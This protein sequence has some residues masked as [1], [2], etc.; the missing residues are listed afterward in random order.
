MVKRERRLV[1][2]W[3][4]QGE[5]PLQERGP[6]I[7]VPN[8][9]LIP[10][11]LSVTIPTILTIVTIASR[12]VMAANFARRSKGAVIATLI[13]VTREAAQWS[14]LAPRHPELRRWQDFVAERV[15]P[16]LVAPYAQ[17]LGHRPDREAP[18]GW[19]GHKFTKIV[20]T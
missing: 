4:A 2:G 20:P 19:R 3:L 5:G 11:V 13:T 12:S 7:L 16:W 10:S 9:T 1:E 8:F 6:D 17:R 15:G 14:A 18:R